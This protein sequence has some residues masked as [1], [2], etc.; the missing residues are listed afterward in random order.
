[1]RVV[2]QVASEEHCIDL[3]N[4]LDH[5]LEVSGRHQPVLLIRGEQDLHPLP[6][7]RQRL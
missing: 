3:P 5:F 7:R 6:R 2:H 1:M 4:C